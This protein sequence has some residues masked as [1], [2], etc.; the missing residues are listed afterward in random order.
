MQKRILCYA[1][2][3]LFSL[4]ASSTYIYEANQALINL[5]NQSGTTNL[6]AGDDQV[7]GAFNLGFTFDF[8]G[9]EF[10]Q[11]R[12]STNGCLHFKTSGAYCNDYTP[13][14]LTSQFTYT[15]VPFWTDLI[16]DSGSSMLAKSFDD[17]TV[18]GWYNMREYNR[19]SDNSF[20]VILWRDDNFEF[21]YGALD[22]IN[23]DVLIGCLLYTSPSPRD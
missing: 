17:K 12:I 4:N 18:F 20:E 14:P 6:N 8:Y 10:T 16:R 3:C 5:T 19:A 2:A 11:S 7:S 23:H 15:L 22:V 13:D 21:R 1:I 9:Q